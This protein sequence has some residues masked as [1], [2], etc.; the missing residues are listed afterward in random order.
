LPVAHTVHAPS[1]E[2]MPLWEAADRY[3]RDGDAVV[4]VAGERFGT[5][6]SRD[7]AA[8]VQRLLGVR[9]VIAGSFERIHRSNLVGMGI[10]PLIAPEDVR[11]RLGQLSPGDR[12]EIKAPE[13]GLAVRANIPVILHSA[14]GQNQEFTAR[15]AVET[16]L[17]V[18]LLRAGGVIPS[19]LR[20]T[21]ET[22][23]QGQRKD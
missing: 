22:A 17:D 13:S 11:A 18:Q 12:L 19:L 20:R 21:I 16:E 4:I 3:R 23:R 6:S 7:W 9:A 1:G 5:G 2:V 14:D 8:K 15:A 10:L